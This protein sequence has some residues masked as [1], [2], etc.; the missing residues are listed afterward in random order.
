MRLPIKHPKK[1]IQIPNMKTK[2]VILCTAL[3]AGLTL[4]NGCSML[5]G[6]M[7]SIKGTADAATTIPVN[8]VTNG[9]ALAKDALP[10]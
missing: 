4:V 6:L 1:Q 3:A 7:K 2:N 9:T 10:K 8:I 5:D